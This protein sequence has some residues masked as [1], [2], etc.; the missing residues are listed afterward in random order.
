MPRYALTPN[1]LLEIIGGYS[2]FT[3][4]REHTLSRAS[5]CYVRIP[6]S[7]LLCRYILF[8]FLIIE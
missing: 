2:M 3:S 5:I 7:A 6:L 1:S 4:D 8:I